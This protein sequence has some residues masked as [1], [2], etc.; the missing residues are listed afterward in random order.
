MV[1]RLERQFERARSSN[2]STDL[3]ELPDEAILSQLSSLMR[4]HSGFIMGYDEALALNAKAAEL[5]RLEISPQILA[6]QAEAVLK[7]MLTT[8]G[9]LAEKATRV[10]VALDRAL[11]IAD[12]KTIALVTSS[13]IAATKNIVSFG[14]AIR[15]LLIPLTIVVGTPVDISMKLSGDPNWEAIRAAMHYLIE[16]RQAI[17]A[18]AAHD[19]VFIRWSNYLIDIIKL[20]HAEETNKIK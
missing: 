19:S 16:N 17:T 20:E 11:D 8:S 13:I 10:V 5:H 18:F 1:L 14:R 3:D 9:L 6:E 4:D 12:E 7:P 2:K 15:P